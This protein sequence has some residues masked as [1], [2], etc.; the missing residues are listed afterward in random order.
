MAARYLGTEGDKV[1]KTRYLT[2]PSFVRG[3]L[4]KST[5]SRFAVHCA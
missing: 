2:L 5:D 1:Y 4:F 3:E